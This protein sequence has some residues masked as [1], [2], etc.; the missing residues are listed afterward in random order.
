MFLGDQ[1]A[2]QETTF[3]NSYFFP[4]ISPLYHLYWYLYQ[5]QKLIQFFFEKYQNGEALLFVNTVGWIKG[6]L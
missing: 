1:L 3:L 6:V 2:Y 4:A 5:V